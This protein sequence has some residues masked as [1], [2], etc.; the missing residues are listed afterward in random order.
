MIAA[1]APDLYCAACRHNRMVPD[2]NFPANVD[3]W[4]KISR[5]PSI[6]CFIH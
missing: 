2:I 1:D 6:A 5:S 3:A 4:R